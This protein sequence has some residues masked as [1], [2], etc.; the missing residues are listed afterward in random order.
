MI[1]YPLHQVL[2]LIVYHF[3]DVDVSVSVYVATVH[4]M[5]CVCDWDAWLPVTAR[6]AAGVFV[7]AADFTVQVESGHMFRHGHCH[8]NGETDV[9]NVTTNGSRVEI[10]RDD[11]AKLIRRPSSA[12]RT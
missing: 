1:P 8:G 11:N 6:L 7:V 5:V 2:I 10:R 4:L 3:V 9:E 12:A